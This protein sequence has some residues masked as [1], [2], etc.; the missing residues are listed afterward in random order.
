MRKEI[1]NLICCPHCKSDL[2]EKNK[3]FQCDNQMC[4]HNNEQYYYRVLDNKPILISLS[5]SLSVEQTGC[6][7][8]ERVN[9]CVVFAF[10]IRH[11]KNT[12]E[13]HGR[14]NDD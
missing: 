5:L 1:K 6:G 14:E 11:K 7:S 8:L 4:L 3:G 2:S 9:S 12:N 13:A 10:P